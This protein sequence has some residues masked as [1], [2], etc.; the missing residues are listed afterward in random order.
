MSGQSGRSEYT[1]REEQVAGKVLLRVGFVVCG[2]FKL[3]VGGDQAWR[4]QRWCAS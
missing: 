3:G 2:L 4:S 1:E